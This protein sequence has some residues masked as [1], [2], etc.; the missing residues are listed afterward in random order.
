MSVCLPVHPEWPEPVSDKPWGA[1]E[2]LREKG[3]GQMD[4]WTNRHTDKQINR[5]FY[6][7]SSPLVPSGTV[8]QKP[9]LQNAL[10]QKKRF[11]D[12]H[13]TGR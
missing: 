9:Y 11:I 7:T 5:I 8:A 4:G 12:D 10:V 1:W 2:G 3:V 13:M 6:K